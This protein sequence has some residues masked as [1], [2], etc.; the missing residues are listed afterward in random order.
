MIAEKICQ[1]HNHENFV[2]MIR[3]WGQ[4]C[5]KEICE[6]HNHEKSNEEALGSVIGK[7]TFVNG[8]VHLDSAV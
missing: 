1:W 6:W 8:T 7:N 4:Y 2:L 5:Q 3:R